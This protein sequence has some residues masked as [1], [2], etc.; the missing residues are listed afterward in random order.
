MSAIVRS[1][2]PAYSR[3]VAACASIERKRSSPELIGFGQNQ[4]AG[5]TPAADNAVSKSETCC[6]TKRG[7][8]PSLDLSYF[9][10]VISVP[11][12]Q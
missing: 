8:R 5:R 12:R 1:H 9:A 6:H 4:R 11:R 7:A 2:P 10:A 3:N